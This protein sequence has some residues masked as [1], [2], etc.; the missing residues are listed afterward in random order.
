MPYI[1][2]KTEVI[3]DV[4]SLCHESM[5][6][7]HLDNYIKQEEQNSYYTTEAKPKVQIDNNLEVKTQ[8]QYSRPSSTG[9]AE[10]L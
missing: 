9:S 6:N 4:H 5:E 10:Y 1:I 8:R 2:I 7:T 3:K